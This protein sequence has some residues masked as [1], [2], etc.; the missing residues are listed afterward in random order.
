MSAFLSS[1]ASSGGAASLR[2]LFSHMV[3]NLR[4]GVTPAGSRLVLSTIESKV[5][6]VAVMS[7]FGSGLFSVSFSIGT[8]VFCL[9]FRVLHGLRGGITL[10]WVEFA[11]WDSALVP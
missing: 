2:V 9:F 4:D 10:W 7:L 1:P 6:P 8:M 5:W 3:H 11:L